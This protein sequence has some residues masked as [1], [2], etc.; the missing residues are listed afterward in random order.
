M[1]TT[2][3]SA[4]CTMV[5]PPLTELVAPAITVPSDTF[6]VMIVPSLGALTVAS[7]RLC[8]ARSRFACAFD[9]AGFSV[10]EIDGDL[11]RT[12]AA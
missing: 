9:D 6:F 11:S 12:L 2:L 8:L 1:R 7:S 5:V 10:L 4:I 3:R